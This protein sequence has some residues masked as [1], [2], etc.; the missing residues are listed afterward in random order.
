MVDC[1]PKKVAAVNKGLYD[2]AGLKSVFHG[3]ESH[4]LTGQSFVAQANYASAIGRNSTRV[5]SCN[6]TSIVRTL[7]ALL[8]GAAS[9]FTRSV[10]GRRQQL[11]GRR[12]GLSCHA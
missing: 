9:K 7:G 4:A 1:T 8:V 2:A 6:T 12:D 5:V 10:F 11:G 3:G